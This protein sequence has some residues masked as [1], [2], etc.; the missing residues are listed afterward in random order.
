M[1]DAPKTA[2]QNRGHNSVTSEPIFKILSLSSRKVDVVMI[3]RYFLLLC[4][5]CIRT[6]LLGTAHTHTHLLT[7]MTDQCDGAKYNRLEVQVLPADVFKWRPR[8]NPW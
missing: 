8:H 7:H 3:P 6:A 5:S 4:Y 2:Q 1:H